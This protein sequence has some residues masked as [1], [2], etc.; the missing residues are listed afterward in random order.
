M[1]FIEFEEVFYIRFG[2]FGLFFSDCR[3]SF[4]VSVG[5][6]VCIVVLVEIFVNGFV[7]SVGV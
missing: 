3:W 1:I 5:M 6:W 7:G 2:F 4:F